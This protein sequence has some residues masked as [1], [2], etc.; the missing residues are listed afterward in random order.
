M[1]GTGYEEI[2]DRAAKRKEGAHHH[3]SQD[4]AGGPG[5]EADQD[6]W[7]LNREVLDE[8]EGREGGEDEV[9]AVHLIA[10][11]LLLTTCGKDL[12]PP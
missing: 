8:G 5:I 11:I 2:T 4:P 1:G 12:A 9:L 3:F 6:R 10:R 7:G